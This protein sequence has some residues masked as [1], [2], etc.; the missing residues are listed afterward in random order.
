[1]AFRVVEVGGGAVIGKSSLLTA[2]EALRELR[3]APER[4]FK[5]EVQ[6]EETG[7]LYDDSGLAGLIAKR[8]PGVRH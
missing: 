8:S 3:D 1:M 4:R 7:V 6:D 5:S 2:E